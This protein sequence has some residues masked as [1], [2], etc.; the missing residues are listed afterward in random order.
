MTSAHVQTSDTRLIADRRARLLGRLEA[1]EFDV[2]VSL[3]PSTVEYVTGYRSLASSIQASPIAVVATPERTILVASAA[4]AGP[5]ISDG[6]IAAEDFVPYGRFFYESRSGADSAAHMSD[7]HAD[8]DS[9][10]AEGLRRLGLGRGRVGLEPGRNSPRPHALTSQNPS[11]QFIDA[12][13]WVSDVRGSKLPTEVELLRAAARAAEDGID[14]AIG[15]A[16]A[17]VTERE[18]ATVV[19]SV[20][21][22]R[23]VEPRFVVVTSG[24]RSALSDA[25]ATDRAIGQGDL[26]R[27][28]IGGVREGYWCDVGRTAVVGEPT[29]EQARRYAAILDAEQA[30]LDFVRA[31]IEASALFELAVRTVEDG[32]VRPYRRHHCGHGIGLDVYE[33][34]II[35]ASTSDRLGPNMTFCF[36]TPFY[37]LGWGGMMVEDTL[38]VTETGHELL[39]ISD[40]SLRVIMP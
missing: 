15:T 27:F 13:S 4:D 35:N 28:D 29:A 11:D 23:G 37:E 12:T 17:G 1:A 34:P 40:R 6:G 2:L 22:A 36:E 7:R 24:E 31:G 5:A 9:A 18:L 21:V 39:T 33:S 38:V 32:G 3:K 20:M 14:A 16:S 25:V 30:Q 19:S 26:V 10:M 8:M